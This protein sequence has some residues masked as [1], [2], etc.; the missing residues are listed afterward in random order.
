M[1]LTI[2]LAGSLQTFVSL[3]NSELGLT[4]PCRGD[5]GHCV[6]QRGLGGRCE[7]KVRAEILALISVLCVCHLL[8]SSP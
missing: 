6:H 4:D 2:F 3:V 5:L 8:L 7:H 1:E